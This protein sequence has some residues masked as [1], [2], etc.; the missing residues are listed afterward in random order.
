MQIPS[1]MLT[2]PI[3]IQHLELNPSRQYQ[4]SLLLLDCGCLR[5]TPS[6]SPNKRLFA[7]RSDTCLAKTLCPSATVW[8][9]AVLEASTSRTSHIQSLDSRLTGLQIYANASSTPSGSPVDPFA[10]CLI[11]WLHCAPHT[12]PRLAARQPHPQCRPFF[13][14]PLQD[15]YQGAYISTSW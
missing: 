5:P 2:G 4:P 3:D 1:S 10:R 6:V 14:K 7:S 12:H 11:L 13:E 15:E 8:F 9:V